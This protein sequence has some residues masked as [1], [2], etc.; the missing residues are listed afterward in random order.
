MTRRDAGRDDGGRR[1]PRGR[2]AALAMLAA[3]G[4]S[5][6]VL[7][8]ATVR[9]VA[10]G[11]LADLPFYLLFF[12]LPLSLSAVG[13]LLALRRSDNAIGW[14]LLTSGTLASVTFASGEYVRFAA[15]QGPADWPLLVPAAW[16]SASG[17][18]P[19]I[20]MLIVFLPLLFPTG[21]LLS[22]RWRIVALIAVG[23]VAA[24]AIGP[25]TAPG[26]LNTPGGPPNPLVPP[27]PL[28]GWIQTISTLSNLV[29]PPVFLLAVLS[30]LLR[31]R[32]SGGVERQQIKW[33]LLVASVASIAFAASVLSVGPISDAA[34]V[35]GLLLMAC[36]PVAIGFAIFRYRLYD[37]DRLISRTV[38]YAVV[39]AV[40]AAV[41]ALAFAGLGT[42]LAPFTASEG[43]IAVAASTLVVFALFA[44]VRSRI[45]AAVDR[46][47]N[48]ARYDAQREVDAFAAR[49]RDEV[50]VEPVTRALE[51]ALVRTVQPAVTGI[52]LRGAS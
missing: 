41:Y 4:A 2:A 30:L 36:L 9:A 25:A 1:P 23:G 32:R 19:A 44:P 15:E 11:K 18:V 46:R 13:G 35:L 50:D 45:R 12:L 10:I 27:E 37:I 21:H 8:A 48:R 43:P 26:P 33:F 16:L 40:L 31:F 22:P 42:L 7:A 51:D 5:L 39:T 24:G 52:W 20:G 28:L 6:V 34:W 29:A 49:V 3:V 47:F 17:F 14:L 38:A